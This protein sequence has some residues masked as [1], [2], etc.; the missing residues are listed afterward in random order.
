VFHSVRILPSCEPL[1]I[2]VFC[3]LQDPR[4]VRVWAEKVFRGRKYPKIVEVCSVSYKADYRLIPKDE[5]EEYCKTESHLT[6]DKVKVLPRTVP[7][8]PLLRAS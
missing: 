4:K 7:F 6:M 8:P 1:P 2:R 5:E 3:I